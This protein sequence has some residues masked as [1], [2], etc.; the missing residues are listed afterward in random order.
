MGAMMGA[1]LQAPL[2]ALMALVELTRNPDI[3]IPA[4]ACIVIAHITAANGFGLKSI[5]HTQATMLGQD[6]SRNPMSLALSRASV[7]SVMSRQFVTTSALITINEAKSLLDQLPTWILIKERDYERLLSAA[8]LNRAL[9]DPE[10]DP[11]LERIDLS[12]IPGERKNIGKVT[13]QATLDEAFDII[14]RDNVEALYVVRVPAPLVE[15]PVGIIL[16]SDIER[17]YKS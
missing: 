13:W 9:L 17:F 4:M 7:E 15:H 3:V 6:L 1:A 8:D 11:E 10:R 14:A 16:P 2:A 12:D 5:F